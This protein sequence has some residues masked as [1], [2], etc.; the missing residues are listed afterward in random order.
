[1]R[2]EMQSLKDKLKY[3]IDKLEKIKNKIVEINSTYSTF[4]DARYPRPSGMDYLKV[5]HDINT[6]LNMFKA[7]YSVTMYDIVLGLS[8]VEEFSNNIDDTMKLSNIWLYSDGLKIS[9]EE[10]GFISKE[11]NRFIKV[12]K[13]FQSISEGMRDLYS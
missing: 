8:A 13:D 2:E 6:E 4:M 12:V 1:M 11:L 9:T 3:D 10:L 7:F 5:L